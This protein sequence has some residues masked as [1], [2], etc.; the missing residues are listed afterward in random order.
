MG[1][2]KQDKWQQWL[3]I[4]L[5]LANVYVLWQVVSIVSIGRAILREAGTKSD[6][7]KL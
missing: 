1:R 3:L 7:V 4:A 6:S 2:R 5:T